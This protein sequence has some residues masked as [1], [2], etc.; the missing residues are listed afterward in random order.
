M[1]K[2]KKDWTAANWC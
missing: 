1:F 2:Q